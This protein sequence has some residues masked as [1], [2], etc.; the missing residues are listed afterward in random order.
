ML[1]QGRGCRGSRLLATSG[2]GCP[3]FGIYRSAASGG[4]EPFSLQIVEV[5]DGRIAGLHN[6]L[7]PELFPAFGLPTRL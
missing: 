5:T 1:G 2:N 7:Y 4:H 3:A 6:F